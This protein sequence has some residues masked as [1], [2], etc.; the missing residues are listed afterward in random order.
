MEAVPEVAKAFQVRGYPLFKVFPHEKQFNPYTKKVA[1]VPLD[2]QGP[3]T[4]KSSSLL[5][6]ARLLLV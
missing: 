1:K 6:A 3:L 5:Q 4:G 2:Y